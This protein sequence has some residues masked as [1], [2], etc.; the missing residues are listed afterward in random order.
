MRLDLVDDHTPSWQCSA[1]IDRKVRD[2][3]VLAQQKV[4]ELH[5]VA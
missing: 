1:E 3:C 5:S 2:F 4:L